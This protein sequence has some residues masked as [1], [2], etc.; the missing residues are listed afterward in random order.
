MREGGRRGGKRGKEDRIRRLGQDWRH[1]MSVSGKG[2]GERP[3]PPHL[4]TVQFAQGLVQ[5]GLDLEVLLFGIFYLFCRVTTQTRTI[6]K[7]IPSEP[8]FWVSINK[9]KTL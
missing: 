3:S 4:E 5:G 9:T 6:K 7:N 2:T 8:F 1:E